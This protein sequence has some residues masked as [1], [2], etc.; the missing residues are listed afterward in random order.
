MV[1]GDPHNAQT[2]AAWPQSSA[3]SH[4]DVYIARSSKTVASVTSIERDYRGRAANERLSHRR[5]VPGDPHGAQTPAVRLQWGVWALECALALALRAIFSAPPAPKL[6]I[7]LTKLSEAGRSFKARAVRPRCADALRC[8]ALRALGLRAPPRTRRL[9]AQAPPRAEILRAVV[10]WQAHGSAHVTAGTDM[11]AGGALTNLSATAAASRPRQV[12]APSV[13]RAVS[14]RTARLRRA[15]RPLLQHLITAPALRAGW[16]SSSLTTAGKPSGDV[17][18]FRYECLPLVQ[19]AQR[20]QMPAMNRASHPRKLHVAVLRWQ[21]SDP[22]WPSRSPASRSSATRSSAPR[23]SAP[24]S[25]VPCSPAPRSPAPCSSAPRSTAPRS[26]G[27]GP[28]MATP[29]MRRQASLMAEPAGGARSPQH[30]SPCVS[31]PPQRTWA[32][33]CL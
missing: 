2:L 17:E 27:S 16:Q 30:R 9:V 6:S 3:Q 15:Y 23:S 18:A 25:S 13:E 31:S 7:S 24:R 14:A 26:K 33:T 20:A 1:P 28:C 10:A 11:P 4:F 19:R 8:A 12:C 5:A 29:S 22:A 32:R 21:G